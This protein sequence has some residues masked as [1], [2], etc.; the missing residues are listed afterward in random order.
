MLRQRCQSIRGFTIVELLI[1]IVVIGILAAIVIVAYSGVT[2]KS[3]YAT[4]RQ[5][6]TTIRKLLELYKVD[7]GDY[8]NSA[9]CVN[10]SGET[11]Y[12]SSWCGWDQ[13]QGSSFIPGLV[14]TYASRIPTLDRSLPQANSYLYQSRN[15]AGDSPG[16]DSYELIRFVN[17]GLNSAENASS[18]PDRMLGSGYDGIAW[19]FKSN[20]ATGWW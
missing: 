7:H 11:S 8:P 4:M 16:T 17:T 15:A 12:Q 1:V 2:A 20:P 19:G 18:N 14:S 9:N 10:T 6:M 13:G 3:Q 5:D